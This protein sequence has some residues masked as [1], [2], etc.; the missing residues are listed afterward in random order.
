[1]NRL[2]GQTLYVLPKPTANFISLANSVVPSS[3]VQWGAPGEQVTGLETPPVG[4]AWPVPRTLVRKLDELYHL[5]LNL[6]FPSTTV[7]FNN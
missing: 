5:T 4:D 7:P 1:M 6:V 2:L 3:H